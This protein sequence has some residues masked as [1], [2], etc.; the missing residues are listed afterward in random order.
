MAENQGVHK[1]VQFSACTVRR[2]CI[3][4]GLGHI[5]KAIAKRILEHP[6]RFSADFRIF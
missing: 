1:K 6:H 2:S 3:G 4:R 5:S